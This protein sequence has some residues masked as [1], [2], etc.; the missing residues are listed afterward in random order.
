MLFYA[1]IHHPAQGK[2]ASESNFSVA[3]SKFEIS[4]AGVNLLSFYY[5]GWFVATLICMPT[6]SHARNQI[7]GSRSATFAQEKKES[8]KML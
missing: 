7:G 5:K 8:C 6:K 3:N 2:L 1:S 4:D